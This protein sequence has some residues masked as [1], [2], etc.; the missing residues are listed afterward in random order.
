MMT[1]IKN[2][3]LKLIDEASNKEYDSAIQHVY[4]TNDERHQLHM[5]VDQLAD[6]FVSTTTTTDAASRLVDVVELSVYF[7]LTKERY[8]TL[9]DDMRWL[10]SELP[11]GIFIKKE[12][13]TE[14]EKDE[15][16]ISGHDVM[17][18][19]GGC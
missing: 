19:N 10:N 9:S 2:L 1:N 4:L 7:D 8:D 16:D 15:K 13:C 14:E 6:V 11:K 17:D 18:D 3:V 5:L 12:L